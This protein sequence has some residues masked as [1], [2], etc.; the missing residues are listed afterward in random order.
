MALFNRTNPPAPE[1]VNAQRSEYG[2]AIL[3][4]LN[5]SGRHIYEGTV[6][7]VVRDRRRATNKRARQARAA[8]RRAAR[9]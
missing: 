2:L 7:R 4:E 6:G 3:L 8:H 9:R 5:R 1:L